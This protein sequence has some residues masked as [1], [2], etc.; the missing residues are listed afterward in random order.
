MIKFLVFLHLLFLLFPTLVFPQ[1]MDM[2]YSESNPFNSL[3]FEN[4]ELDKYGN[5]SYKIPIKDFLF[6]SDSLYLD[7]SYLSK[8]DTLILQPIYNSEFISN[9]SNGVMSFVFG[10]AAFGTNDETRSWGD[11]YPN[12][13]FINLINKVIVLDSLGAE[14]LKL[15]YL[16]Y[17]FGS[18]E[19]T[20]N[21]MFLALTHGGGF[22][23]N[24]DFPEGLKVIDIYNSEF[25][26]DTEGNWAIHGRTD[27]FIIIS[28]R[29][30]PANLE[31]RIIDFNN[32]VFYQRTYDNSDQFLFEILPDGLKVKN[33]LND[34]FIIESILE[35]EVEKFSL[36]K[37]TN[38]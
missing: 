8:F 15:D 36:T 35:F 12:R 37:N 34:Q 22:M 20:G 4:F 18:I 28:S 25:T 2:K 38:I 5:K 21:G 26:F 13:E 7:R 6:S 31:F 19:V 17:Y 9:S 33:R 3:S 27:S 30:K 11:T 24:D 16:D 29:T 32:R 1:K 23:P 10:M 14:I